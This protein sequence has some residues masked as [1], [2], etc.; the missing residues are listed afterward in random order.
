MLA[1]TSLLS[2]TTLDG[3][4]WTPNDIDDQTGRTF[5]ITG[6]NSGI[7]LAAAR[8]LA[9]KGAHIVLAVRNTEKGDTAAR[10]IKGS[11]EVRQLDLADLDSV[12]SFS[13][14]LGEFDVLINN[15][16]VMNVA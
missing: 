14:Q 7:G 5:V 1:L 4:T 10:T 13:D 8:E 6:A 9:K 16:G 2:S 15:S 12:L 3:M 11:T